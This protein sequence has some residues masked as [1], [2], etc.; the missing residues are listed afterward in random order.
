M[1]VQKAGPLQRRAVTTMLTGTS[2]RRARRGTHEDPVGIS[3]AG[4]KVAILL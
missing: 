1:Q 4:I 2:E 3:R